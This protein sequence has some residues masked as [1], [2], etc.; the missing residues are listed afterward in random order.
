MSAHFVDRLQE[1]AP[2]GTLPGH[3]YLSDLTERCIAVLEH[4]DASY[5]P[6]SS[7]SGKS[8]GLLDF[9]AD[10]LPLVIVPDIHAR[11]YFLANILAYT[12]PEGFLQ[13]GR[14]TILEALGEGAVQVVCVGDI[15]HS[16]LRGKKRWEAA[17]EEYASGSSFGQ[18]MESEMAE[19]LCALCLLMECKCAF[20]SAFH[21]LKGN[22]ENILNAAGAGNYPFRKFADEGRMTRRFMERTYGETILMLIARFEKALPLLAV[23]SNGMVSH[24]EPFRSFTRKELIDGMTSGA[25][26]GALTWTR[27]DEARAGSVAAM[28]AQLS[29]RPDWERLTYFGGHRPVSGRYALREGGLFVQI[30]NPMEQNIALAYPDRPFNPDTDIV[31]VAP[32]P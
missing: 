17:L 28:L 30:H 31:S 29:G 6:Y 13:N 15:L 3:Q 32:K 7:A 2:G 5:R 23:F 14:R 4:E 27:N 8:G 21:C 25:V 18:A 16:E 12:P 24:A 9:T 10:A 11:S 19:G 26:V 22:H 20:P 1:L